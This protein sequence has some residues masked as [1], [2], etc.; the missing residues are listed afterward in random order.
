MA[1]LQKSVN[2][3]LMET[4]ATSCLLFIALL[5]QGAAAVPLR[6]YCRLEESNF[7]VPYFTNYTF[8]MAEEVF[9]SI[10]LIYLEPK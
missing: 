10:S 7:Q 5:V 3:S 9:I 4:L 8:K 6:S 1:M 2:F